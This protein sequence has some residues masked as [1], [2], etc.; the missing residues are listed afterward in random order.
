MI[1]REEDTRTAAL[2]GCGACEKLK[3]SRVA[4]FGLG[5]VGGSLCE[6][7]ARAGVGALD[8]FDGDT[9]ALS[10]INRQVIALHS[11]VGRPKAEVAKERILDIN[12]DC[13]VRA[14]SVFYLT[15]NA[16]E[17]PLDKY[18]YI[19]DAVDN[20][21]AKVE[22]AVRASLAGVPIISAMGAG[23]KLDPTRFEVADIY[24]TQVCPLAKVMRKELKARGVKQMKTVYSKEVA[25][26][27]NEGVIGSVSFVPTVSGLIMAGEIIKD[28]TGVR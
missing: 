10:N 9:V 26:K 24:D 14:F 7:L 27:N 12:P 18:D 8:I 17:Y 23:N 15:E 2:M 3:N 11:N 20:V 25:R 4:V 6:A 19:A 22:L 28:I 1:I 21:S 16:E 5:G 13:E